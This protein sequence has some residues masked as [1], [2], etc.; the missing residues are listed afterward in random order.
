MSLCI[1]VQN[2]KSLIILCNNKSHS[3]FVFKYK[4]NSL[5]KMFTYLGFFLTLD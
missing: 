1:I 2:V 5:Q 3:S 4:N